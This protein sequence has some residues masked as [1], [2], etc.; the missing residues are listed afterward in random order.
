[1]SSLIS[2]DLRRLVALRADHLCEYCLI[3]EGDGL[4]DFQVDHIIS[5]KHGGATT[6]Q[7]LAYAC[8]FCNRQKGS[9]LGTVMAP[10][11]R[12]IRFFHP[13]SDIWADHFKISGPMIEPLTEIAGGTIRILG[14]N[15]PDRLLERQL[16]ISI[17]RY[18]SIPAL[19]RLRT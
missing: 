16:L 5:R 3:H 6:S 9:D 8:P 19:A 14:F 1:M 10:S 7:N 17:G 4:L 15:H 11:G 2:E 12:L 13:R 18:P